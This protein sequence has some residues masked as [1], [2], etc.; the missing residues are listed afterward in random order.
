MNSSRLRNILLS[1]T[2]V[3]AALPAFA[4]TLPDQF[5][6]EGRLYNSGVALG[7]NVDIKFEVID[8]ANTSCVLYREVHSTIDLGSNPATQGVFALKLGAGTRKF[9]PQRLSYVFSNGL[10]QTGDNN[11]DNSADAACALTPAASSQRLVKMYVSQDAGATW[12]YLGPDTAVTTTPTAMVAETLQGRD[13]SGFILANSALTHMNQADL[14]YI[15]NNSNYARIKALADGSST[16]YMAATPAAAVGFNNQRITN[17]GTPTAATDAATKGYSDSNIGGKTADVTGVGPATGNGYTLIWDQATQKWT[18]G[19]LVDPG[20]LPKAGGTMTGAINMNGNDILGTGHITVSPLKTITLGNLTPA[21]ETALVGTLSAAN[22]GATWYE[23]TNNELKVWNGSAAI[24]Q[25]YLTAGKL[26]ATWLPASVV[27]T[28]TTLGGDLSGSLPNPTIANDKIISK[29]LDNTGKAINRLVISDPTTGDNLKFATCG[30]NEVLRYEATGWTC[31]NPSAIVSG[32]IADGGNTTGAAINIGVNDGHDLNLKTNNSTRMTIT[33]TG[34][35]G[36]GTTNPGTDPFV[37][38]G[39]YPGMYTSRIYNM[40]GSGGGAYYGPTNDAGHALFVGVTGSTFSSPGIYQPNV[41]VVYADQFL[42]SLNIGT[43]TGAPIK[44]FAGPSENLRIDG[45]GRLG[46]GTTSPSRLLDV[47]GPIHITPSTLSGGFAGDL[48]I[49]SAGNA[50]KWHNGSVWKTVGTGNGDFMKDGTVTMTGPLKMGGQAVYGSASPSG[51]ITIDS[52]SD[53][54]KGAVYLNPF[55]G[56]VLAGMSS[57]TLPASLYAGPSG[58]SSEGNSPAVF[59]AY[60]AYNSSNTVGSGV[61]YGFYG[62]S[63]INMAS[64]SSIWENSPNDARMSFVTRNAGALSEKMRIQADGNVGI[65]ITSPARLLHINGPMRLTPTTLPGSPAA[66]DL[67]FDSL[68]ANALKFYDGIT[69]RTVGTGT[70]SGDFLRNGTLAMT[71][72]FNAG[73]FKIY[74]S[75]ASA[76]SLTLESTSNGT[77]GPV[78]LQPNGGWV[79]I[80]TT[81]P[82]SP[83]H[84]HDDGN[85]YPEIRFTTPTNG[86]TGFTVGMTSLAGVLSF[87][88]LA[89]TAFIWQSHPRPIVF[90]TNDQVRMLVDDVGNFGVGT[91][92][93]QRLLHVNGPIRINPAALPGSPSAGDLAFDSNAS[94]A[95]KFFDGF[96][97]QTVGTSAGAGDF[98]KDGSVAMT[99]NFNAGGNSILGNTTASANLKLEST[100]SATKGFV[101]IQ[102]NGGNVGIG[103]NNPSYVLTVKQASSNTT[104]WMENNGSGAAISAIAS[105][106]GTSNSAIYAMGSTTAATIDAQAAGAGAAVSGNASGSSNYAIFGTATGVAG[107]AVFGNATG[108]G[109]GIYGS[110]TSTGPAGYFSSSSTGPALV[111]PI[112][113]VGIGTTA[114]AELL[115]VRQNNSGVTRVLNENPNT[116]TGAQTEFKATNDASNSVFVGVNSSTFSAG[117]LFTQN[118]GYLAADG[119][120]GL[121]IGVKYTGAPIRF[122][123]GGGAPSERMRIDDLGNVSIGTTAIGSKLYVN[124]AIVSKTKVLTGTSTP[125]F[126]LSNTVVMSGIPSS[127]ITPTGMID[128]GNYTLIIK[129]TGGLQ[130]TINGQCTTSRMRPTNGPTTSGTFSVYSILFIGGNEC[131]INWSSGY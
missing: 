78:I 65:G 24:S 128:G 16:A 68:A 8:S 49:D 75:S 14:E 84:I 64:V 131:F 74:G 100:S 48:A 115:H 41:G 113:N 80:S 110:T 33:A 69:W 73:G 98:K 116:G 76:G 95:F 87:A 31:R 79:G 114:P 9:F 71:G 38:Y 27:T 37:I 77:K 20:A 91:T 54:A 17:V 117:G 123:T 29:M 25:A 108:G 85:N 57:A 96:T 104:A 34:N 109:T 111:A 50:L 47:N 94:N 93:P 30:I 15:F 89:D 127:T 66:G 129:D 44:F 5:T 43:E 130:Y 105:G 28:S 55:G 70:G 81:T 92:S 125:D 82:Q 103:T 120:N 35:V 42:S 52:T 40:N 90:A 4:Q 1:L 46:V 26:S 63:G 97:W 56:S 3:F 39:S 121:N 51:S 59:N 67:A 119:P 88:N 19:A 101:L 45:S 11:G 99:G 112:G 61:S 122:Y 18:T 83:L 36:V 102:P 13:L 72:N 60:K 10:A 6:I 107:R 23:S 58:I 12:T 62:D 32:F 53:P 7:G 21:Q 86:N 124:G 22:K 106:S 126:S 2:C 118:A